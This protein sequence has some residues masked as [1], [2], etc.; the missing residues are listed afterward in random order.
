MQACGGCLVPGNIHGEVGNGSE[1]PDLDENV[2]T[3]YRR[4]DEQ[5][6]L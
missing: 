4:A 5:D 1:P 3:H 6:D 2:P